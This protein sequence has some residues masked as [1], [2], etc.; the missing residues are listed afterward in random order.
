M[1]MDTR[2]EWTKSR[3][4][5]IAAVTALGYPAQLGAEMA[6]MLGS[7]RAMSRMASYLRNVK[8]QSMELI[9]DELLSIQSDADRWRERKR[10]LEANMK[11]NEILN[12]GLYDDD[13]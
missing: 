6:K 12:N 11:Y 13:E 7:P 2:T 9:A 5:L 10:S 3:D 8:P 4:D 1:E